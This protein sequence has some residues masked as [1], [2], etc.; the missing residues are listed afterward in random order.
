M[1][2]LILLPCL[3]I[4]LYMPIYLEYQAADNISTHKEWRVKGIV[5]QRNIRVV[6]EQVY[7]DNLGLF[8][9]SHVRSSRAYLII[10]CRLTVSRKFLVFIIECSNRSSIT[11]LYL[12]ADIVQWQN[13][14]MWGDESLFKSGYQPYYIKPGQFNWLEH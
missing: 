13:N 8:D 6:M 4:Y 11:I 9:A 10:C 2:A 14:R 7:M 5:G 12:K 3:F 1:G